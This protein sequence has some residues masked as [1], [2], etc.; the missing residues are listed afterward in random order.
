MG[1]GGQRYASTALLPGKWLLYPNNNNNNNKNNNND[2]EDDDNKSGGLK[3]VQMEHN[4]HYL[5]L[6]LICGILVHIQSQS[7]KSARRH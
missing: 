1:V 7:S 3:N 2:D 4:F 6:E 5:F